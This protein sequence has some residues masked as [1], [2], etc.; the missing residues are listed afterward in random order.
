VSRRPVISRL[1]AL[2]AV[3]S[4]MV[5]ALVTVP[6]RPAEALTAGDI[7]FGTQRYS[8][9]ADEIARLQSGG[10]VSNLSNDGSG[11]ANTMPVISPDG[12]KIAY[13][14]GNEPNSGL[15]VS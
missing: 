6:A 9:G 11:A 5:A 10:T 2:L 4:M 8:S 14:Q 13:R 7:V 15:Y 12:C 1:A 3:L